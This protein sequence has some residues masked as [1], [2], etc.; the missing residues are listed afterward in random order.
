MITLFAPLDVATDKALLLSN[1]ELN[2]I[3]MSTKQVVKVIDYSE[4]REFNRILNRFVNGFVKL[5]E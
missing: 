3:R 4:S 2:Y 5:F 1:I